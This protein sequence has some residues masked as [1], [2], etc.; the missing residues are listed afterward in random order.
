MII[1]LSLSDRFL[2]RLQI[3]FT[4]PFSPFKWWENARFLNQRWLEFSRVMLILSTAITDWDTSVN[5]KFRQIA[6]HSFKIKANWMT[7]KFF[8]LYKKKIKTFGPN[9]DSA[10]HTAVTRIRTWVTSATTKGTN[11]YTITAIGAG[12][13]SRR[14]TLKC[15]W[16]CSINF[17]ESFY[18]KTATND[19]RFTCN[20]R[21]ILEH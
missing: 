12:F 14:S 6:P 11:H 7:L 16:K 5:I 18:F 10:T 17:A 2:S 4:Y 13:S 3:F 8:G 20:L 9:R 1:I 15:Q 21:I 19:D